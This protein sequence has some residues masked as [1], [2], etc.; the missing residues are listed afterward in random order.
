ML[1]VTAS[2]AR[3]FGAVATAY[4]A[5]RP[6]YPQTAVDWALEPVAG[7]NL[8]DLGAGTGK[9][10]AA[11]LARPGG[12][13][14]AVEPDPA[15][16]HELRT[17]FPIVDARE[18]SAEE[19]P[20][21]AASVDGVLVGA[22]W[23]WFDHGRAHPEIARVLR[24]GGVLAALWNNDDAS[25]E[26]VAGYHRAA[27][28]GRPV[29]GVPAAGGASAF[30][31]HPAFSASRRARFPN[32][33]RTTIDGLLATVATHSW[34]LVSEPADRDAA[35]DRI[36]TYLDGRPETSAGEFELPLV[37]EVLRALRR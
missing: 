37:T 33:V 15:M 31:P 6:G 24:P 34:A 25:V 28:V 20:L 27:D 14:T 36:R 35:F 12:R 22:A 30:P 7:W 2:R 8:L 1:C 23:H 21:P 10:T 3:S 19:I 9:L 16:L 5:H 13:V 26:W 29:P 18:G 11:L 32:P 4:A 17:R